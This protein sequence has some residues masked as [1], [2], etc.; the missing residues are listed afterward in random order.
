MR[1]ALV[2]RDGSH[3]LQRKGAVAARE[4]RMEFVN[5][6][7][8]EG[9]TR[10]GLG[11]R[12]IDA[13]TRQD[14]VR[15]IDDTVARGSRYQAHNL[16]GHVRT[17]F[18]W[19]IGRGIYGI[20]T[21][22]C[23]RMKP[24]QLI[25]HKA[26]RTRVLSDR[27]LCALWRAAQRLGYPYGPLIQMLALTG[28][29]RSE[30][31]SATWAEFDLGR[32][33][34]VIPAERMKAEAPHVVPLTKEVVSILSRLPRF[35]GAGRGD[36]VFS[37]TFGGKPV[38]G[39]SKAKAS[40]DR[41]MLRTL[42]ALRRTP[43]DQSSAELPHFVLHDIRRTVRTRLS[44]LPV[45]TEVAEL[46]IAHARP[47]LRRV[48]DQFSYLDEKRAGARALGRRARANCGC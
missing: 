33:Q 34:W 46:V 25:G 3:P 39:F 5:D 42:R 47:G 13:V 10:K 15:V 14:I 45:S 20:E 41:R 8:I 26:L 29:R 44:G 9:V 32:R 11:Q 27:E 17:F 37:T 12:P 30:V 48:Y 35:S 6:K 24:R 16:L 31:A 1:L 43:S 4:L 36:H 23:D 40:L 19:A 22:P 7:L 28:Q 38:N 21:S 2:G 18:N